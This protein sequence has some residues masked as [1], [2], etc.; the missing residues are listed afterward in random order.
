MAGERTFREHVR[1]HHQGE[2]QEQT[3]SKRWFARRE[4]ST[5]FT[6]RLALCITLN[7]SYEDMHSYNARMHPAEWLYVSDTLKLPLPR[8]PCFRRQPSRGE[9]D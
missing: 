7:S 8:V 2:R 1:S 9:T 3:F 6:R 4:S 5:E